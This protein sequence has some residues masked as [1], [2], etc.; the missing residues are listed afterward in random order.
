MAHWSGYGRKQSYLVGCG[1]ETNKSRS[2]Y[3]IILY[4]KHTIQKCLILQT[5]LQYKTILYVHT[6]LLVSL[7]YLISLMHGRGLFNRLSLLWG[8]GRIRLV[9]EQR[10]KPCTSRIR[11]SRAINC[12]T[13]FC[14]KAGNNMEVMPT[15][16]STASTKQ[17]PMARGRQMCWSEVR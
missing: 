10:F 11:R 7:P 8:T 5:C 17:Q 14:T 1:K 6:H 15:K 16:H 12:S 3:K 9:S 4:C 13:T 2:T